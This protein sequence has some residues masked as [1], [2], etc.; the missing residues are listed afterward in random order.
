MLEQLLLTN[1]H[2]KTTLTSLYGEFDI[3]LRSGEVDGKRY[4][5]KLMRQGCS[6]ALVDMQCQALMHVRNADNTIPVPVVVPSAA[7]HSYEIIHDETGTSRIIW[8]LEFIEGCLYSDFLPRDTR[9][10]RQLGIQT[11]LLD[12]AL[13]GFEHPMLK[14][15]LPWNLM[16]AAWISDKLNCVTD[17]KR[18]A[19]LQSIV[20]EYLS[21][22]D[23]LQQLPQEVIHND[24]NDNNIVVSASLGREPNIAGLID[25]GDMCMAPR[26][27]ELA[28]AG[29]YAML[30]QP[31]AVEQ[32]AFLVAGYHEI[33]A[34]TEPELNL[35]VP[36][37]RM[38]L[39]V[40]VVSSTLSAREKPNDPYVVVSQAPAWRLLESAVFNTHVLQTLRLS[41]GYGVVAS[42]ES[43][44]AFLD[45]KR[46]SFQ[47]ILGHPITDTCVVP[48]SV[49]GSTVPQNPFNMTHAEA[50]ELGE[51]CAL[52]SHSIALGLYGEP[53]LIYTDVA[54]SSG[55]YK[56]GPRRTVHLGLDVFAPAG[57]PIHA[58]MDGVVVALENCTG[59]LDYGGLLVLS[60]TIGSGEVFYSLYGHLDP[61][62][63]HQRSIGQRIKAGEIIA[64]LG[65]QS[66]NG[67]WS[68]HL[69]CQLA[70]SIQGMGADWP[71]VA[72]PDKRRLWT[73]LCPNPAPLLNLPDELTTYQPIEE[74][75][76]AVSR[77]SLFSP[78][79]KLSYRQP[80]MFLRG[81]KHYLI[82]QWGRV[83]LDAYNNVPHVG[84][85]H[86]EIQ[87]VVTNQL[88]RLNT[89]TRYLHP[90]QV[91]FAQRLVDTLPAGLDVCYF[92]NSGSEA[93]ELA[94]RLA[95]AAT[96]GK[97]MV[98]LDH[99]YHGNTTGTIDISAYKFNASGGVGQSD[100]V[101]LVDIPDVYRGRFRGDE[102]NTA[103]LYASQIVQALQ[104]IKKR[105]GKL[106]G[107]MAETFPSV[108]GQVIPP[109]GYLANVYEQ[110]RQA[111]GVC[112]ADEVQTGLGRLGDYFYGFEQ[113][114]AIPDI[115]VL[116]KPLG[117][118]H[119][120]GAVITTTQIAEQFSRG[121]E[122][123]S[124]F[125]GST[126]S[127]VIGKTVLDIVE[128]EGLQANAKL[129]GEQLLNGLRELQHKHLAIGDVRGVGLF[130]G[131]ELVTDREL[132]TPA[133]DL[134]AHAVNRL[135]E[136]RVLTGLE[137][138]DNNILKIRPPLTIGVS[139]VQM[140]LQMIDEV[141]S[142]TVASHC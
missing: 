37:L 62:V 73:A 32:L 33:Q 42:A 27:C 55:Q 71:G 28:I 101:H 66:N 36:L 16:Q 29:A 88:K 60:H 22:S 15:D 14:R 8:V 111:G 98:T 109:T 92:V 19:L 35:L 57:S 142:E 69:H 139:D 114:H 103:T 99:G 17:V 132:L 129:R 134:A 41:C 102:S 78:N 125:G 44:N 83:Y 80:L 106:A 13:Q 91:E 59:D 7:G 79:L 46:G 20:N 21:L 108:G 38:R 136:K 123:F 87:A 116:G 112:I 122:F 117:N 68:P 4:L 9:L 137:G 51:H 93:N 6:E 39:A 141:L 11:A 65:D 113:Q 25:M 47:H 67:G 131:L 97:D 74:H 24:I 124:T 48:L 86:P 2:I 95:R 140:I 3:N 43:V 49:A 23:A 40:S 64:L 61:D 18:I 121:P 138:P 85:A 126:L 75:K 53:R 81:W 89:N 84:H 1:W 56:A 12:R 52:N 82:D 90:A 34:L 96:G 70:L 63:C 130:I 128:R 107:F 115:V 31:D 118:G 105:G 135:R 10:V 58:P 76:L 120:M 100:W 104:A 94:L 127:C 45:K 54:F 26:I 5:V 72:D 30:D 133:T 77:Q 50:S 119:P 110:I